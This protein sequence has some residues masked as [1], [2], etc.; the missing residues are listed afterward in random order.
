MKKRI[1]SALLMLVL[2]A[3]LVGPMTTGASASQ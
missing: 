2:V 1:I 3:V